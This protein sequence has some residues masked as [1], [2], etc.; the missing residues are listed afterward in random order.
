M[1]FAVSAGACEV[2]VA[3]AEDLVEAIDVLVQLRRDH[4]RQPVVVKVR[5]LRQEQGRA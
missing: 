4:A 2:R 3:L 5:D 1:T